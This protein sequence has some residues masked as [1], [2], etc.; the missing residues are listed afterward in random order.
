MLYSALHDVNQLAGDGLSREVH[1]DAMS[2]HDSRLPVD[3]DDESWQ[4]VALAVHQAVG[5][6]QLIVDQSYGLAGVECLLQPA[7]PESF[8][9]GFLLERQ[10]AHGDGALL[11]VASGDER[12][13]RSEHADYVALADA[14]VL[15][16]DGTRENPGVKALQAFFL[17]PFEVYTI[18]VYLLLE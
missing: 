13:A 12:A 10:H 14:F 18:H 6:G 16:M 7:M 3:V 11:V 1:T 5:G 9:D 17:S 2:L 8:V 4:H 15:M